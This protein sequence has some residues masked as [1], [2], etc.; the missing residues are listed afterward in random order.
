M[1]E[2]YTARAYLKRSAS[3]AGG[4]DETNVIGRPLPGLPDADHFTR[5]VFLDAEHGQLAQ[6]AV[7]HVRVELRLKHP[8]DVMDAVREQHL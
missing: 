4:A 8:G 2:P 7:R 1:S 5:E 6:R 3:Q